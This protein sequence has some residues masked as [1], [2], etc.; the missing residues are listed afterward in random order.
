[1]R[2]SAR[3]FVAAAILAAAPL[4]VAGAR[5]DAPTEAELQRAADRLVASSDIPAVITLVEWDGRQSVVAAGVAQVGGRKARPDDRFWVGSVTKSFVATLV[6]QLVAERKLRLD[7]RVGKVLPGR[8][9]AGRRIRLRNLLNHTSGIPDYMRHEPWVSAVARNPRVAISQRRLVS[10]VAR[11]PLE[12]PPGSQ[13]SYSNTNYLVLAEILRRVTDR[14]VGALLRT[15]LFEPLRLTATRYEGGS[16]SLR[17]DDLHGYDLSASP[18]T[19]VSLHGLG[20]PWADGGIV[21]N[22][23]DLAA[24]FGALLRGELVPARLLAQMKT[25]VA[26]SHGEGMGIYKLPSSCGRWFYGHTGGTPGYVT[27]AA[28]SEDGSRLF[29]VDWNGVSRDAID[30]MDVYLDELLCRD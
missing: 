20:G 19:D 6:M 8:L 3:V 12:F 30:V 22:A 5:P 16:R 26:R 24:F 25:I 17:D 28:G 10:S 29:V 7:D 23:H 1:M 15:R 14:T 11:L 13:A 2:A 9:L 21:S 27:F 18:P 4:A